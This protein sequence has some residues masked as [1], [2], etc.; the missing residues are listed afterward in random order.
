MFREE[1]EKNLTPVSKTVKIKKDKLGAT[2]LSRSQSPY[3]FKTL[4]NTTER[5]NEFERATNE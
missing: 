3:Q 5:D 1:F 2:N 4:N